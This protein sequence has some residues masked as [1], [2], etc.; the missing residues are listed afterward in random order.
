MRLVVF[1]L[2]VLLVLPGALVFA[3]G[4]TEVESAAA[5][6]E[7]LLTGPPAGAGERPSAMRVYATPGAYSQATGDSVG[8]YKEAPMLAEKVQAGDLP[9]VE[10]R[11]PLEPVVVKPEETIGK[12]GGYV[13]STVR[14]N[15]PIGSLG[16]YWN[17]DPLVTQ[18]PSDDEDKALFFSGETPY[19][20]GPN[21]AK[22]WDF[23]SDYR[24]ITLY[25]REGM[26]WSDGEPYSAEDI[27]FWW[28]DVILNDSLTPTKP[29]TLKRNGVIAEFRVIDDYTIQWSFAEPSP[30]W[31]TYLASWGG[32]RSGPVRTPKH[33]LT[34]F[35]PD[36]TSMDEIQQLMKEEDFETWVD[37]F[38]YKTEQ[39]NPEL[40]TTAPWVITERP[41]KPFQTYVRNP[42]YW[43][44]D[45]AGNQLP[46][47]DELRETRM[48]SEY[49]EANL[50]KVIAGEVDWLRIYFVGG[51]ANMKMLQDNKEKGDYRFA[52]G[53]WMPNCW[54]N[55][56]FNF[57][58]PEPVKREL[59]ND[60]RFRRAL[61]TAIN[62]EEIIKLTWKAG[63]S[64]S[65]VAPAAGPPYNGDSELFQSY[66]QYDPDLANEILDEIGLT[67]RDSQGYRT[68][69]NGEELRFVLY[70][71]STVN[72][73]EACELI[74][75]YWEE[76]GIK[77]T[78]KTEAGSL[79]FSRHNGGQHDM[80]AR[81]THF[82]GG[83]V[84]P[85]LNQN[86]FCQAGWLWAPDW[87]SWIE[88]DGQEGVEPPDDVK[89]IR[90]YLGEIQG[91]PSK[92]KRDELMMEVF[93]IH[94]DNIWSIGVVKD[95]PKLLQQQIVANR[96]RNYPTWSGGTW[97]P[98]CPA[99]F[100]MNE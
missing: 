97:Y 78:V 36:Y 28:N 57:S 49:R 6:E 30:L 9:P 22:G 13:R 99:Q 85:T 21:V 7:R 10:E 5:E 65:Q 12:Y 96:L 94:M 80:S 66:A 16:Q 38:G 26:R 18:M 67:E 87:V 52:Y 27:E 23:S 82:G 60:V 35:H 11:L 68:G 58:S 15:R 46:Y 98:N 44:V 33:Y 41:P 61:S 45:T 91:E 24:T 69:P 92:T 14:S 100:F 64:A 84:H 2:V 4:E 76:V 59:Y 56:M 77:A 40:P 62:R 70:A 81:L 31:V 88:T 95:D 34:Q 25:L 42:Y 50:L 79:W 1:V 93:K 17:I 48:P 19:V 29:R 53:M 39:G 37:F 74:A 47:I 71:Y 55:I 32:E 51:L 89:R 83:P 73:P 43:K 72:V 86:T 54:A 20:V 63:V 90:E 8:A 3:G 75:G